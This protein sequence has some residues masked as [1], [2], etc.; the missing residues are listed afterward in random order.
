MIWQLNGYLILFHSLDSDVYLAHPTTK[1]FAIWLQTMRLAD[2]C[3]NCA[4]FVQR[5]KLVVPGT[6]NGRKESKAAKKASEIL[7]RWLRMALFWM[8]H[9]AQWCSMTSPICEGWS[10]WRCSG[11][12]RHSPA[13]PK[14]VLTIF[15]SEIRTVFSQLGCVD[16][17]G[18]FH[19]CWERDGRP[20]IRNGV[21]WE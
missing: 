4:G 11:V 16:T 21:R 2:G 6:W 12:S 19:D 7:Q 18:S 8:L 15:W 10:C 20:V 1:P 9:I 5:P 14:L 17:S 13:D 3:S